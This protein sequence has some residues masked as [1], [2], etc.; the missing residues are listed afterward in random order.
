MKCVA[1]DLFCGIGGLTHGIENA[2]IEVVAGIDIDETC[3][4][5]YEYN[6]NSQFI[7]K[8]IENIS[9]EEIN[10]LFP[11]NCIKILMGCAPCQPFSNYSLRYIKN[12]KR[13][14]RWI[15]LTHFIDHVEKIRPHIVSMENVPQLVKERVFD[16]FLVKLKS[17]GYHISWKIVNCADFGVPQNRNRLVLL[18]S[19]LAP[20]ELIDS[21]YDMDDYSTVRSAIG[22]MAMLKD[23]EASKSDK[24][25][26][27]SKLSEKN[28]K[29]I[30]QS[31]PGGTWHDWEESLKLVCH[32]RNTGKGYTAVYGRMEYDKPSPTITTKFYG[33][34][35]GRFGHPEQDRAISL[36]EGALLQSFPMNYEF[37]N[38]HEPQSI[39]KIGV[40]IGN[41]VPVKLGEAV[42]KSI[43][44]H[45]N[46]VGVQ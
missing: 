10:E 18:A 24:M 28:R 4:F 26:K 13:N 35:N 22:E 34:G 44:T 21:P 12:R 17:F 20:I 40:H 19:L 37:I 45:I 39:R 33:Y 29:R 25:H 8:G 27:C 32:M 43:L 14:D 23:G 31:V 42:G 6:N 2:G 3:K 46:E 9:S 16:E 7:N 41:A 1:V 30:K 38:A 5:S 11:E 36:R 15:L